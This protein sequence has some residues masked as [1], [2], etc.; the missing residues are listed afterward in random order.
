MIGVRNLLLIIC[1]L[2]ITA[3]ALFSVAQDSNLGTEAMTETQKTYLLG[4]RVDG[5]FTAIGRLVFDANN[6]PVLTPLDGADGVNEL[7]SAL[8]EIIGQ[9]FLMVDGRVEK[10]DENGEIAI[11]LIKTQV[12]RGHE[13]YSP[14]VRDVLS[15][16]Y[17]Y[18]VV[19][20]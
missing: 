18:S 19:H 9:E 12:P 1:A 6:M 2:I 7:Q 3:I 16:E 10:E 20:E 17:G 14:A 13:K 8:D 5:E 11:Q 15:R 4:K